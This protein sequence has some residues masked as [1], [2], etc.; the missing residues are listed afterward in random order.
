MTGASFANLP[1]LIPSI[2]YFSTNRL[3][4]FMLLAKGWSYF[5]VKWRQLRVSR[6]KGCRRSTHF[7]QL[8]FKIAIPLTVISGSLHW[9][10]SQAIFIAVVVIYAISEQP[11]S[12][13][14][15]MTTG[16]APFPMIYILAVAIFAVMI[17]I[18]TGSCS[19]AMP[20]SC[21][22]LSSDVFPTMKT[23]QRGVVVETKGSVSFSHCCSTSFTVNSPDHGT[24]YSNTP[25]YQEDERR[26]F[27]H[28]LRMWR[29]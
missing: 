28:D 6:P 10:T 8:P 4:S 3:I 5:A 27:L 23:L 11:S 19:A 13:Q 9:L 1:Q 16:Y 25:D 29:R 22:P 18:W 7:L 17:L 15:L 14:S 24:S 12:P 21:H 26:T 20:A 2:L